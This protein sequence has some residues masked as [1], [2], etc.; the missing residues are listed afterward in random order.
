[1]DRCVVAS[2]VFASFRGSI[3]ALKI[4]GFCLCWVVSKVFLI[5]RF[6]YDEMLRYGIRAFA[7]DML[8]TL[9]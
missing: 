8:M 7:H 6:Y 1:M 2:P 5:V 4:I 9:S 3:I